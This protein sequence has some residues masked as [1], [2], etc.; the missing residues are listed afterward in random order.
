M[1]EYT[2][3]E[4]TFLEKLHQANWQVINQGQG[5][6]VEQAKLLQVICRQGRKR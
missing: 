2:N 6:L 1:A 4:K 3:I 5:V